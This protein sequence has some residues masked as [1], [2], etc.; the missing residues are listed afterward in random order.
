[1]G[2]GVRGGTRG[3]FS[4]MAFPPPP[5]GGCDKAAASV[6]APLGFCPVTFHL[7]SCLNVLSPDTPHTGQ[8]FPGSGRT[9]RRGSHNVRLHVLLSIVA[10]H[11]RSHRSMRLPS[12]NP[13]A[14][15]TACLGDNGHWNRCEV[16]SPCSFGLHF[17]ECHGGCTSFHTSMGCSYVFFGEA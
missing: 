3:L 11:L 8:A 6:T 10:V 16:A 12:H 15:V 7:L 2:A 9:W 17:P 4:G 1:M 14:R 13:P 5:R